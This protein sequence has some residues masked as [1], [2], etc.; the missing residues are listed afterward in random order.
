[1][2]RRIP[3]LLLFR[4]RTLT[5]RDVIKWIVLGSA[6][7]V[8]SGVFSALFIIGLKWVT[9]RRLDTPALILFLPLAGLVI[10]WLY[11]RFAG[12]AARG[13]ALIIEQLHTQTEAVPFRMTPLILIAALLGHLFGAS[14]GREGVGVQMGSSLADALYRRLRLP[15]I[16]RRTMLLA[17]IA[18]G[19]GS[20]FGTPLAGLVF[21][22]EVRYMGSV[23]Y[24]AII[25]CLVAAFTGDLLVHRLGI[26][27]S[28]YPRLPE[29]DI[30]PMML[31]R[32]AAISLL[33]GLVALIFIELTDRI[34]HVSRARIKSRPL[35]LFV[36]GAIITILT[37]VLQTTAYNGLSDQFLGEAL[38]G[39]QIAPTTFAFKLVFT[40]I[41]LGFG[42]VGGEVMPL[43]IM[44]AT[45]GAAVGHLFGLTPVFAAGLGFVAVFGAAANAPITCILLAVEL[46]GGGSVAYV[47]VACF[48]AYLASGHRGIYGT[49]RLGVA[50]SFRSVAQTE[51]TLEGLHDAHGTK[52]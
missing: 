45:F 42:F 22:M 1:L 10:G 35:R 16:D 19:F 14:V 50:K 52:G 29:F 37:L 8:L 24:E 23:L 7:G 32:V 21:A 18:G 43:F 15:A 44:G 46:F 20:V 6:V 4:E 48:V 30:E 36:G 26:G 47:A 9:G 33:F 31:I 5:A 12:N 17:G 28:V 3:A 11:Q 2:I 39:A 41:S 51:T 40:A 13:S 34:K 38:S 25:P 49:Q 27:E